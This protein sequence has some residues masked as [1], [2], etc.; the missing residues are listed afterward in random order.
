MKFPILLLSLAAIQ[1]ARADTYRVTNLNDAGPGSLRFAVASA[2]GPREIVFDAEGVIELQSPLL[3]NKPNLTITGNNT[4]ISGW[5]VTV[6]KTHHVTIRSMRFRPGDRNCP[7]MQ[8]DAL[9]I[10]R[11]QDILIDH[12]SASWSIDEVLSVSHSDRVTVQWSII[13]ESLNESC[14]VKGAH[15][16]GSLI[17]YGEGQV[18][19]HHNLFAHNRSRNPRVGDNIRFHFANNVIYNY[20]AKGGQATYTGP[21]EEGSP[22]INYIHNFTLAGPST[23]PKRR[24][25]TFEG[26][27]KNTQLFQ[28]GNYLN[29]QPA[30]AA[31]FVGEYTLVEQ[32]FAFDTEA[33]ESA[34]EA[35]TSVLQGAGAGPRRDAVDARIVEE[36]RTRQG[37]IRNQPPK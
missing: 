20:G 34:P 23:D 4:T 22:R 9:S 10:D 8:G 31:A 11:A 15:G 32:R 19:F 6:Q 3:I 36:V 25:R 1:I 2:Q 27:S 18:T 28:V 26:G 33:V 29:S 24:D 37:S 21:A 16:Y 30:T 12:V 5:T 17:R 7:A 14:H 35:F 13:A